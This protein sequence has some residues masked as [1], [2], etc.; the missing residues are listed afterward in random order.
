MRT[1]L[2]KFFSTLFEIEPEERLK[3]LLLSLAFFLIIGAYTVANE[4]KS[5]IFMQIVG[6]SAI[7]T[8]RI[9]GMFVLIPLILIYSRL[10]DSM[11][12]YQLLSFY[13]AAYGIVGLVFTYFLGHPTIGLPNM[14]TS[15]SRIFGWLFYFFIEG[16]APFVIS[17]FWAFANSVNSP[18]SAKR[19]Y[20]MI[21]AASKL[22]GAVMALIAMMLLSNVA[23]SNRVYF[24]DTLNHQ[25]LLGMSSM[26]LI[27]VVPVIYALVKYVPGK[28]LHGYEAVYKFEKQKS[29]EER[30]PRTFKQYFQG[31]LSS[32]FSGLTMFTKQPYILGI[33]GMSFMY[34]IVY[35]IFSYIRLGA[36]QSESSNMTE[37]TAALFKPIII[38]Q[39]IG[40]AISIFGTQALL[41]YFGERFCLMLIPA[42]S[43]F[44]LFY[45]LITYST[46][47]VFIG[48][49]ALRAI[50]WGFSQPIRESLY[51]P[52]VKDLKFK[53]KSWIDAFGSKFAKGTGSGFNMIADVV[54]PEMFIP[55]HAAFFSA[56][57]GCWFVTAFL[58]GKRYDQ[59][60]AN[61][62]VIGSEDEAVA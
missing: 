15:S 6:R 60:I 57:I 53:S 55:L 26:L 47:A 4:L 14:A 49:I 9:Y 28:Y 27:L 37:V 30:P 23:L 20:T 7:P 44:F 2:K 24:S 40:F 29:K 34:E 21:V 52:T 22:G 45:T 56:V 38:I 25:L 19:Y 8:A 17:V 35:V 50:H 3:V 43:G 61:N 42:V 32:M 58:L 41:N 48:F 39:L 11:R 59:A 5:S 31:T 36:A 10:V 18:H 1:S 16:Y 12:R 33:F 51:I 13:S 62:E 54:R 46:T